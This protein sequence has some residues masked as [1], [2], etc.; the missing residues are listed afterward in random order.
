MTTLRKRWWISRVVISLVLLLA[1]VGVSRY[2]H[3]T[4][5][6]PRMVLAL[7]RIRRRHQTLR[8]HVLDRGPA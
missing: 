8:P 3:V 6:V 5:D 1:A 2:E 4:P 7:L